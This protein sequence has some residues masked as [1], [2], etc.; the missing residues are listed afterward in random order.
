MHWCSRVRRW[1]YPWTES[2]Q[3]STKAKLEYIW[4]RLICLGNPSDIDIYHHQKLQGSIRSSAIFL[5][6]LVPTLWDS[7]GAS[8][9]LWSPQRVRYCTMVIVLLLVILSTVVH[10]CHAQSNRQ[11]R[12][13]FRNSVRISWHL[14]LLTQPSVCWPNWIEPFRT[15]CMCFLRNY[16]RVLRPLN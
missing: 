16:C 1:F 12:W 8:Q 15:P 11:F 5:I 3:D 2:D 10:L 9:A 14:S 4:L 7:V 13:S 6:A